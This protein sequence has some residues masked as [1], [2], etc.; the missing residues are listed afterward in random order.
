MLSA[1]NV[2]FNSNAVIHG[3]LIMPNASI[4]VNGHAEIHGAIL[5]GQGMGGNGTADLFPGDS[6]QGFNLPERENITD[7]VIITAWH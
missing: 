7:N 3:A 5:V 2:K 4:T 1:S 6:G